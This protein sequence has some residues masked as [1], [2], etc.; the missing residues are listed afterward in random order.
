MYIGRG[1]LKAGGIKAGRVRDHTGRAPQGAQRRVF[2][3]EA[4]I[5]AP[6]HQDLKIFNQAQPE[7]GRARKNQAG[8]GAQ[9]NK[10]A[11]GGICRNLWSEI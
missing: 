5:P 8:N 3:S 7:G 9:K 11:R 2:L 10:H 6:P 4:Y 1:P